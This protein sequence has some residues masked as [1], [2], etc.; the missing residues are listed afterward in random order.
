MHGKQQ[1]TNGLLD[2]TLRADYNP[3]LSGLRDFIT[4][5]H[6]PR[7]LKYWGCAPTLTPTYR[8]GR[9]QSD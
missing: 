2:M 9:V 8:A 1:S 7:R 5:T 4:N 6:E 3:S